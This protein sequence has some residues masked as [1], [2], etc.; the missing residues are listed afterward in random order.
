M[1]KSHS[2]V[3]IF[4]LPPI[5]N[6]YN[7]PISLPFYSQPKQVTDI[8][9]FLE[10]VNRKDTRAVTIKKNKDCVKFKARTAR[11]LVTLV[12]KDSS[13]ADKLAKMLPP[14]TRRHMAVCV[15]HMYLCVCLC[16]CFCSCSR[17]A[18]HHQLSSCF[19]VQS[20]G[21]NVPGGGRMKEK[22]GRR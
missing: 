6:F 10:L 21:M 11:F 8:K 9:E 3:S 5:L 4:A 7:Y 19:S 16:V 12:V 22:R 13:K 20:R 15:I 17:Q 1:N 14:C 18:R 2:S